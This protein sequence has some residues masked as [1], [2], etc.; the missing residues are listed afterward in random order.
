MDIQTI[1]LAFR[2]RSIKRLAL[3]LI[4]TI[5]FVV[6]SYLFYFGPQQNMFRQLQSQVNDMRQQ[7]ISL[8]A[9]NDPGNNLQSLSYNVQQINDKLNYTV[10][11]LKLN[12]LILDLSK[13]HGVRIIRQTNSEDGEKGGW[14]ILKQSLSIEGNYRQ[15]RAFID[16]IYQLPSLTLIQELN[17]QKK[18]E[19]NKQLAGS[20]LLLTYHRRMSSS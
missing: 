9:L 4:V 3:L 11:S 8:K 6:I 2:N 12:K 7:L 19:L 17:L 13:N 20:L 14:Q 1:K 15:I 18:T 16:G 5:L 10:Q